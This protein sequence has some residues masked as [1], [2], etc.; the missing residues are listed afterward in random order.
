MRV[1]FISKKFNK[2]NPGGR[3]GL[4]VNLYN[5]LNFVFE[6]KLKLHELPIIQ[7]KNIIFY[8]N[9]LR[10]F[11]DGIDL[12]NIKKIIEIITKKQIKIVI[13][14]GSNLGILAKILKKKFPKLIIYIFFHNV[15]SIFFWK[16]FTQ[17]ISIKKFLV[18]LVNYYAEKNS[19]SYAD[20]IIYLNE[21]DSIKLKKIYG[22]SG[23]FNLPM[24]INDKLP[25]N[26]MKINESNMSQYILFVG[27]DFY[28]NRSGISWFVKNI[29]PK[30]K[31]KLVIIGR[32]FEKLKSELEINNK[33][34][35]LGSVVSI[36]KWY[37]NANLVIAPIF[38]GSGMKTKIAEGLMFGKKIIGTPEAFVGYEE[39][40]DDILIK[41]K[42]KEDF[43]KQ[44]LKFEENKINKFYKIADI[45]MKKI[46]LWRQEKIY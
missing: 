3:E 21:R 17:K 32:G 8:L 38:T 1:L 25:S 29:I 30:I 37:I 42:T 2:I 24:I 46:I 40:P 28:A 10:G 4:S 11:I 36:A 26:Y 20:K 41:C 18:W 16:S 27:A 33:V 12:I 43:I 5:A 14:D 45:I 35:V 39:V 15:E 7:K 13:L 44:I 22:R 34:I 31:S 23:D 9:S 6:K 19:I